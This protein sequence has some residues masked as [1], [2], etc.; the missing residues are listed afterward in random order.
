MSRRP[1]FVLPALLAAF[2]LPVAPA[3]AGEDDDD[4]SSAT[5]RAPQGCVSGDHATAAVTGENIA[6]V[7]FFLDGDLIKTATRPN[8]AGRFSWTVNCN[9]LRAGAHRA[10]AVVS[11]EEGS[12]AATKTLRF[13]FTR[14]RQ[15]SGSAG[16]PRFTG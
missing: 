12:S 8:S 9:H 10:R 15:G 4:S 3:L 2:A 1:L 11:F 5:L 14:T 6:Q 7:R 13:Q 16:S